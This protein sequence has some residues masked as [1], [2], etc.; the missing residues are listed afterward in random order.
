MENEKTFND[1]DDEYRQGRI[2]AL[3]DPEKPI[4]VHTDASSAA[5][6][7][8]RELDDDIQYERLMRC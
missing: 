3:F 8:L 4:V 7:I 2:L 5:N 1:T 6:K